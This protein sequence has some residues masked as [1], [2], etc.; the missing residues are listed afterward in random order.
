M[1]FFHVW[2]SIKSVGSAGTTSVPLVSGHVHVLDGKEV[3]VVFSFDTVE[4]R[5]AYAAACMRALD[6]VDKHTLSGC[7]GDGALTR[8]S[9]YCFRDEESAD[10]FAFPASPSGPPTLGSPA[11]VRNTVRTAATKVSL[12]GG[13][14]VFCVCVRLT[15]SEG[16]PQIHSEASILYDAQS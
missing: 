11:S 4:E 1:V 3:N 5:I 8:H 13:E 6:D 14:T 16:A 9:I 7:G 12:W 2:G 15:S 10:A